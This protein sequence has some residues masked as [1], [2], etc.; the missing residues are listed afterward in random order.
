MKKHIT[1]TRKQGF[2]IVELLIVIVVIGILAA[3]TIVTFN[4]VQNNA[5]FARE[6][7]DMN[8]INKVILLYYA[9]NG[10]YPVKTSWS[11]WSQALNDNFIPGIVP[12]YI[13]NTPQMPA[14]ADTNESYLYRSTDGGT[15][16]KLIRYS[17]TGGLP[18][19]QL[20]NNALIDP[21]R[22]TRAWGYWSQTGASI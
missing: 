13:S 17:G 15:G 3:I 5:K 21:I 11:G 22:T 1:I 6:K 4:G 16:Y 18:E 14:T 9:D 12:K 10:F 7:A 8:A 2:T 20:T 19:A